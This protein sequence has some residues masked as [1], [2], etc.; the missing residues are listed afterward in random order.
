M[1]ARVQGGRVIAE[2]EAEY[3]RASDAGGGDH[4]LGPAPGVGPVPAA[5]DAPAAEH[6]TGDAQHRA[7]R[8]AAEA[9]RMRHGRVEQLVSAQAQARETGQHERGGE[10]PGGWAGPAGSPVAA[11]VHR[12]GQPQRSIERIVQDRDRDAAQHGSSP[13]GRPPGTPRSSGP[14]PPPPPPTVPPS[15]LPRRWRSSVVSPGGTAP[16]PSRSPGPPQ[17][18]RGPY[19]GD[20]LH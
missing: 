5:S 10:P 16:R 2:V 13:G 8:E 9:D 4:P 18:P 20:A 1:E 12:G 14:R 3:Y 15:L 7:G 6:E 11:G 19:P 17:P